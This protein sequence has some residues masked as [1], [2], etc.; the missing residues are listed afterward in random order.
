MANSKS[1]IKRIRIN[2]KN[3]IQNLFY[4]SAVKTTIKTFFKQLETYKKS[5]NLDDKVKATAILSIAYSF[6]DKAT[7]KNI[8]HK[9]TAARK[10]ARLVSAIKSISNI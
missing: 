2:K 9:N 4:K 8:L 1:A 5:K 3:R 10:K 7:K 6:I